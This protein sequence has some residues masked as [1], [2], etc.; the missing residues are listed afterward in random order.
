MVVRGG[1]SPVLGSLVHGAQVLGAICG[2]GDG[3]KSLRQRFEGIGMVF[4]VNLHAADVNVAHALSQ[5]DLGF[6]HGFF[7]GGVKLPLAMRCYGPGP[8]NIYL[9]F[10]VPTARFSLRYGSQEVYWNSC[11][12]LRRLHRT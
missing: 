11:R 10:A 7:L 1:L 12:T 6:R 8:G 3:I 9:L 5:K 4:Q 2:V